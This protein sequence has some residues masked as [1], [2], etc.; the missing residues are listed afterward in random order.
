MSQ[1][2]VTLEDRQKAERKKRKPYKF[3]AKPFLS[4][5]NVGDIKVVTDDTLDWYSLRTMAARMRREYGCL[6]LFHNA[7]RIIVRVK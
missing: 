5:F 6:F 4:D 3:G 1:W 2:W 7:E